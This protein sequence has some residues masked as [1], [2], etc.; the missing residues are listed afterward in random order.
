MQTWKEVPATI[1]SAE[2]QTSSGSD[3][4]TYKTVAEYDYVYNDHQ[5][6]GSRV[7]RYFGNDNVG[8]F[9]QDKY[10]E[11]SMYRNSRKPFRCYVNPDA[12]EEA[13]LYREARLPMLCFFGAFAGT[14]G[15]VGYGI[16]AVLIVGLVNSRRT[17]ALEKLNPGQPWKARPDWSR[18]EVRTSAGTKMI[19]SVAVAIFIGA[20]ALPILIFIPGEVRDGNTS[21]LYALIFPLVAG[22]IIA[23]AVRSVLQW[24]RFGTAVLLLT[25]N[26]VRPGD[27]LR[28]TIKT[29]ADLPQSAEIILELKCE[30]SIRRRSGNKTSIHKETAW[31]KIASVM[32]VSGADGKTCIQV[33][34]EIP[35]T[36]PETGTESSNTEVEWELIAKAEIPGVDLNAKFAIPVFKIG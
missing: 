28:G 15:G 6:K 17:A 36:F 18:N 27:R 29:G 31:S 16:L 8:S 19:I 7:S 12:P 2:L 4:T 11:L 1:R 9:H 23:W 25:T 24:R 21:A 34:I 14:F 5:Y 20:I 22:L 13:I 26:P 32:G 35:E 3:S 30:R 10:A 33:D